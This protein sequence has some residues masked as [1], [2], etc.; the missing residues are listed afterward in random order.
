VTVK[1]LSRIGGG[2]PTGEVTFVEGTTVLGTAQVRR[3]R[4]TMKTSSLPVGRDPIQ[5]IYS[6]SRSFVPSSAIIVETVSP[7]RSELKKTAAAEAAHFGS[8]VLSTATIGHG[9]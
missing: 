7:G 4:A 1:N 6:G 2:V 9:G 3:G 5:V 8:Q